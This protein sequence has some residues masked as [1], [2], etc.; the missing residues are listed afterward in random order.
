MLHEHRRR[1]LEA[2]GRGK[3]FMS[4]AQAMARLRRAIT[5]VTATGTAPVAI[6]RKVFGDVAQSPLTR[7]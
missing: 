3:R 2:Q 5:K 7:R 4:Y 1:R 6:V